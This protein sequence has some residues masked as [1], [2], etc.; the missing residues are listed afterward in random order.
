VLI[1]R[2]GTYV[3]PSTSVVHEQDLNT[4]TSSKESLSLTTEGFAASVFMSQLTG[5][6]CQDC[7]PKHSHFLSP[8]NVFHENTVDT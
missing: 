5:E 4:N 8:E 6:F 3:L 1:G 7:V 2:I